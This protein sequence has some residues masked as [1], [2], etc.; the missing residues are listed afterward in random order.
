MKLTGKNILIA[1]GNGFIG[2]NLSLYLRD[3]GNTVIIVD[4]YSSSEPKDFFWESEGITVINHDISYPFSICD[5]NIDV[6]INLACIASPDKYQAASF[7]TLDSCYLGTKNLLNLLN[8]HGIFLQASTSEIY[9]DS[10]VSPQSEEYW[11][12]VNPYGPRSC[13]DEGKRVSEALCYEYRDKKN[14]DV[15][16]MRI[17]N[18][19]GP[20]MSSSDGRVITNF[21]TSIIKR[22]PLVVYG[23]GSQSRSFMYIS[24][25]LEGIKVLL[26]TDKYMG[27]VNLGN[28]S[29]RSIMDLARACI[30]IWG[31]QEILYKPLP[32]DDPQKRCPDITKALNL[33]WLGPQVSLNEGL[34]ETYKWLCQRDI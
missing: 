27:P 13:Y 23:T 10:K 11:G 21:L 32:K 17:F 31:K 3:L 15:R 7:E 1:G 30:D 22:S 6:I 33:G 34:L 24:D 2:T 12:N 16:I 5:R 8:P 4:N 26:E 20:W 9:G 29:E 25:L 19:Y 28:P 18:T 14:L